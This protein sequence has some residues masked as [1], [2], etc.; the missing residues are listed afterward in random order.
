MA[1]PVT[2]FEGLSAVAATLG[3][4]GPGIGIVG[5]MNNYLPFTDLSK[6]FMVFLMWVG[7]LEIIPVFVLLTGAYWRS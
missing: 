3:N 2:T 6:L 4:V 7:R 1:D 5:P